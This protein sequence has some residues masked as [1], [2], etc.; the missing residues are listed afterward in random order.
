MAYNP[1]QNKEDHNL[2][3]TPV[4][5]E[6]SPH[7]LLQEALTWLTYYNEHST[8]L[9]PIEAA[10]DILTRLLV[11][12]PESITSVENDETEILNKEFE[13]SVL[14]R[15]E[16]IKSGFPKSVVFAL[17]DED[18]RKISKRM[19]FAHTD[20]SYWEDLTE[21]TNRMLEEKAEE[22]NSVYRHP[23]A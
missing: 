13:V 15:L 22:K 21:Y 2:E 8:D 12:F 18:M 14:T 7:E 9:G 1:D 19:G 4:L 20:N 6:K 16:L 10:Q 5:P 23:D 11:L 17:S 3:T